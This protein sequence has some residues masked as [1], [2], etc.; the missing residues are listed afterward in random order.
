MTHLVRDGA[1]HVT[2]RLQFADQAESVVQHHDSILF[3]KRWAGV[4]KTLGS[5]QTVVV[6]DFGH[7]KNV[8]VVLSVPSGHSFHVSLVG[9][10]K[11]WCVSNATFL[12][13]RQNGAV[14]PDNA[15]CGFAVG[16]SSRQFELDAGVHANA[17]A[18]GVCGLPEIVIHAVNGRDDLRIADVLGDA[19]G[20]SCVDHVNHNG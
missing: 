5:P 3:I 14:H 8:D 15:V 19:D 12:I 10:C 1:V 9:T 16:G 18:R 2:A 20:R 11:T 7:H 4:G 6:V 17:I 13:A